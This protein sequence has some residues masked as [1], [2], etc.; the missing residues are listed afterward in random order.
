MIPGSKRAVPLE[1]SRTGSAVAI[2]TLDERIESSCSSSKAS[3]IE[4]RARSLP[5]SLAS[6]GGSSLSAS[7]SSRVVKSWCWKITILL[8]YSKI[9]EAR[10]IYRILFL[11]TCGAGWYSWQQLWRL[12]GHNSTSVS[13][14]QSIS[15]HFLAFFFYYFYFA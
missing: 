13:S 1:T 7:S 10:L 5:T 9:R 15:N 6:L 4:M 11:L 2:S 3:P 14:S 12:L 8:D